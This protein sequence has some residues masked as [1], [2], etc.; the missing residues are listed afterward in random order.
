D[1]EFGLQVLEGKA[2]IGGLSRG[3][4][5]SGGQQHG[6]C[7]CR[8]L[9]HGSSWGH[10]LPPG[11]LPSPCGHLLSLPHV[12]WVRDMA[13]PEA[14]EAMAACVRANVLRLSAPV[15]WPGSWPLS[16]RMA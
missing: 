13:V 3:C 8:D 1:P 5:G 15:G 16:A 7:Q 10:V 9:L 12:E 2:D 11:R 4:S 14:A 6:S